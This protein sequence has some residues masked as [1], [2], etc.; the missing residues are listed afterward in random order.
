MKTFF[1]IV[2]TKIFL[3]IKFWF[4]FNTEKTFLYFSMQIL[5][6]NSYLTC[7][8]FYFS[9]WLMHLRCG[10]IHQ[11]IFLG[12]QKENLPR[13]SCKTIFKNSFL[14]FT[15]KFQVNCMVNTPKKVWQSV[16]ALRNVRNSDLNLTF[17][18]WRL[19]ICC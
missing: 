19:V 6:K 17:T 7:N 18:M 13:T 15:G 16:F 10:S 9:R 12:S 5:R 3:E 2:M 14:P 11:L 8:F 1:F 4:F